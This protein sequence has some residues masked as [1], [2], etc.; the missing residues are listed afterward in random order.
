MKVTMAA[1]DKYFVIL[2]D[3]GDVEVPIFFF[4]G[5]PKVREGKNSSYNPKALF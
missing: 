2:G 4:Y 5:L 1:N 3:V